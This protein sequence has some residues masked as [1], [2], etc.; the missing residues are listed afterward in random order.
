MRRAFICAVMLALALSGC[1][2][3]GEISV[4]DD[5]SGT[6]GFVFALEPQFAP[7]LQAGGDDPFAELKNQMNNAPVDWKIE[8]YNT[9][10]M[11]GFRASFSFSSIDDLKSKMRALAESQ[12]SSAP[13]FGDS[14][15]I[16]RTEGG[17]SVSGSSEAPSADEIL[18]TGAPV[19]GDPNAALPPGFSGPFGDNGA[20][21][22][23]DQ[24]LKVEMRVTLPGEPAQHNATRVERDGDRT[25]FIWRPRPGQGEM[26]LSASTT[27]IGGGLPVAQIGLVLL[28]LLAGASAFMFAHTRRPTGTPPVVLEGVLP[29]PHDLSAGA[30]A[31]VAS[32][33]PDAPA[34]EAPPGSAG[35]GY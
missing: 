15:G 18:G 14:F 7:M 17:W 29:V 10:G 34:D 6:F 26:A 16:E 8:D 19:A 23:L 22:Q 11:T 12:G 21:V 35:A 20:P 3:R 4:N 13:G 27:D 1:E 33:T 32:P 2:I 30:Y 5:G 28:M 31:G 24:L 9:G 25:T